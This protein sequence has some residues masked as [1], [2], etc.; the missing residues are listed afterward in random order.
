LLLFLKVGWRVNEAL[1]LLK[2]G[3]I[4]GN[5]MMGTSADGRKPLLKTDEDN[6]R[7]H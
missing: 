6:D 2:R 4:L 3:N 5:Q 1:K 7:E